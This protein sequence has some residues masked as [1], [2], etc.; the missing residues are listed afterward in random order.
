MDPTE[1]ELKTMRKLEFIEWQKGLKLQWIVITCMFF[2]SG[3]VLISV[4]YFLGAFDKLASIASGLSGMAS[5]IAAC[6]MQD[7]F[8]KNYLEARYA[9]W[10]IRRKVRLEAED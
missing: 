8:K 4:Y 3:I 10:G 9:L 1:Q 2:I 7:K 5:L 6:F